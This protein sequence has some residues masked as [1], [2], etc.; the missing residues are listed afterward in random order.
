MEKLIKKFNKWLFS[1]RVR[2]IY[3]EHY[4]NGNK[5]SKGYLIFDNKDGKWN[6][7]HENGQRKSQG[8]YSKNIIYGKWVYWHDNAKK[9]SE[10]SYLWV[11]HGKGIW[12]VKDNDWTYWDKDGRIEKSYSN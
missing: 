9:R 8:C 6:E 11:D 3:A 2:E 5:K 4:P 1:I 10:G 7:W 12:A